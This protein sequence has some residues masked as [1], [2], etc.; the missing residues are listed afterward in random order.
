ME[1]FLNAAAI[2]FIIGFVLLLLEFALP[3]LIVVFFGV[4]AW[5]VALVLLFTDISINT[6]II[7]FLAS[8]LVSVLL[9]RKW[10][11]RRIYSRKRLNDYD[12]NELI[13]K[14]CKAET[15]IIPG[16]IGTVNFKGSNWQAR[17][18]ERI[19]AGENVIIIGNDSIILIVKPTKTL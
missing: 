17:S 10:L 11:K 2:W 8:S 4:G 5:V 15:A 13:G 3:G 19:E 16:E 9:L 7:V 12:D 18:D 1:S 6:Q 14:T